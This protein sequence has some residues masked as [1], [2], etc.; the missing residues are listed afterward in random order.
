MIFDARQALR[1]SEAMAAVSSI[2]LS[3]EVFMQTD[4][5]SDRGLLSWRVN[6]LT[7]PLIDR[8]TRMVGVDA[9]FRYQNFL[10]LQAV[11]LILAIA[12]LLAILMGRSTSAL[13]SMEVML[14]L[15][16]HL[17]CSTSNDGSDQFTLI[18]LIACMFAELV[19]TPLLYVGAC[20]FVAGEAM[21]A[22][23]TSGWLKILEPGW[24]D[25]SI[26][27]GV[28]ATSTFGN[29][30]LYRWYS[31]HA[32]MAVCSG[33]GVAVGD[34]ILGIAALLPPSVC[35]TVLLFG[36]L[37]HVGIARVLGLNTFLWAFCATYP[38]TYFVSSTL[39]G[40]IFKH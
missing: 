8:V 22:Y 5:F 23:S 21:V 34:C 31:E 14:T 37:L 40:F 27:T 1:C 10:R 24:R 3:A 28:L 30:S 2:I 20:C 18:V 33:L 4:L 9:V 35:L 13:L 19:G 39:Y 6:R 15:L 29:R 32:A 26:I 11:R 17:R 36:F 25:G 16:L 12:L 38:P 7:H